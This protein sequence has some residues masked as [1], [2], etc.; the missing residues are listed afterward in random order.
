MSNPAS[1]LLPRVQAGDEV[2]LHEFFLQHEPRLLRMVELRIDPVLRRRLDP[3]DVL[4]EAWIEIA[5]RAVEW[6]AQ[7]T[8]PLH[9]WM[10]LIT[11]QAL[12]QLQ[13]RH[14]GAHMRDALREVPQPESRLSVTAA[15]AAQ[16][17]MASATSPSQAAAREETCARVRAAL[18]DLDELDREIITLRHIEELANHEVAAELGLDP[19]TAS[20]R[21]MRA[22]VRLR[23][24]LIALGPTPSVGGA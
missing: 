4:Q 14:L 13:R 9:V 11:S 19:K 12:Q 15:G 24:A 23:P 16:A 20:K 18:E 1:D 10:R 3:S 2:A 21:Y 8:L 22:L 17:F 6:R 7:A 5:R